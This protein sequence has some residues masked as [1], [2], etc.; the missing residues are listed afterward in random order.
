MTAKVSRKV[1]DLKR[2]RTIQLGNCEGLDLASTMYAVYKLPPAAASASISH[3]VTVT[4]NI[5]CVLRDT[6]QGGFRV[7][8]TTSLATSCC[9]D[10]T[11]TWMYDEFWV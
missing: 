6:L 8:T 3:A 5:I 2:R 4:C 1:G 11:F 9:C 10:G 7:V